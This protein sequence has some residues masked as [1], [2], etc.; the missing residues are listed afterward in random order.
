VWK[1]AKINNRVW[2]GLI[3]DGGGG[4]A[5]TEIVNQTKR[6]DNLRFKVD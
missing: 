6:A 3:D 1:A 4:I 2:I 5:H